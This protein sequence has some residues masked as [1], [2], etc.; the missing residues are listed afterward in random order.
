[1]N[2]TNIDFWER[3]IR[4]PSDPYKDLFREEE[5]YLI[6]NIAPDASV[7][8]IGCGDGRIIRL[9]N[10][11]NKNIIGIDNDAIAI[12]DAKKQLG[13]L[14]GV[15]LMEADAFNLPFNEGTFDVVTFMMTL[16]NFDENKL[17]AL[18]EIHRVLKDDGK[19]LLSVYSED[20]ADTRLSMYTE[21][22][23]PIKSME[24][25]KFVFDAMG[26][27]GTSE[28]FSEEELKSLAE[29]TGFKITDCKKV[30]K[31]AYMCTLQKA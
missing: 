23:L 26:S 14:D 19:L 18:K 29:S 3:I 7:L 6:S 8:D 22:G 16:V 20:A 4:N 27:A 5:A 1:M 10:Q 30:D 31:I 2:N 24:K 13:D 11:V 21:V 9:I 25:G 15:Q 17:V 28:Q 12:E